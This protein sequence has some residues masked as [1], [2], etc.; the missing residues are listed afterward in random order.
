M[1]K[2]KDSRG[3][4]SVFLIIILVPM[5]LIASIFVDASRFKLAEGVADSAGELVLN[6]AL[7]HYDTDLKDLYGLFATAQDTDE[8]YEKLEDYYR[9]SMISAG[10][11]EKD[12]EAYISQI[13][14]GLGAVSKSGDVADL[15][16]IQ[17]IDFGISKNTNLTLANASVLKK[18]VVDFMKYRAPINTGL[19]FVTSLKSFTTL[20]KQTE[21]VEKRQEYY[22]AEKTVMTAAQKAWDSIN[23]YN[24]TDI[25][26]NTNYLNELKSFLSSNDENSLRNMYES[27]AKKTVKDLYDTQSYAH[28]E[29]YYWRFKEETKKI[30][31]EDKQVWVLKNGTNEKKHY[32]EYTTYSDS[33]K[34]SLND[35][36]TLI[37]NYHNKLKNFKN[38]YSRYINEVKAKMLSTNYGLQTLVQ[39]QRSNKFSI[40]TNYTGTM[41]NSGGLYE[42][43]SKLKHAVSYHEDEPN[44]MLETIS[45]DYGRISGTVGDVYNAIRDEFESTITTQYNT[46]L[47]EVNNFFQPIEDSINNSNQT[48][49]SGVQTKLSDTATK[50]KTYLDT[51][52]TAVDK[53]SVAIINLEAVLKG[54]K[55]GGDLDKKTNS[56]KTVANDSTVKNTSMAVQDRAEIN[57]LNDYLNPEDVQKLITRLTKIK[58]NINNVLSEL[59]KYKYM[60]KSIVSIDGYESLKNLLANKI[61]D[62]QLKSVPL[63]KTSLENKTKEWCEN[64]F[65]TGNINVSWVNDKNQSPILHGPN[66]DTLKFYAYLYTHF[67]KGE[68]STNTEKKI[69][70]KSN[71]TEAESSLKK[72]KSDATKS[73]TKVD[74]KE[75]TTENEISKISIK[76]SKFGGN[77][78]AYASVDYSKGDA[79]T[80]TKTGLSGMLNKICDAI[81]NMGTELRDNL[82]FTDYIMSMFSYDTIE[83]ETAFKNANDV[84][85]NEKVV[86]PETLTKTP[87][88]A[89]NNYAY[90]REIEYVIYGGA[91][92]ENIKNACSSIYG[93]RLAFNMIYAFSASQIR[94]AAF[95]MATPISAASLGVIPVPLIQAAIIVGMACCESALDINDLRTGKPVVLLKSEDT[96]RC[97]IDGLLDEVKSTASTL[98]NSALDKEIDKGVSELNKWLDMTDEQLNEILSQGEEAVNDS[99]STSFD[100]IVTRHADTAIQKLT[101]AI[102]N[103]IEKY[104]MGS[105]QENQIKSSVENELDRWLA[106]GEGVGNALGK[107][108]CSTAVEVIKTYCNNTIDQLIK[109]VIQSQESVTD[110]ISDVSKQMSSKLIDIKQEILTEVTKIS[111]VVK[112]SKE[113]LISSTRDAING[114]ADKLKESLQSNLGNLFGENESNDESGV[115]SIMDFYYSDYLKLFVLIGLYTNEET[116]IL[117]CADAIQSNMN[118][119]N[120]GYDITKASTYVNVTADIQIKPLLLALPLFSDVENN[121]ATNQRCYVFQEK[122]TKGY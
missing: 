113:Q 5:L 25:V 17:L 8:L 120:D 41:T 93:F 38:Y 102:T 42:L 46:T 105:I 109:L 36:K 107:E 76:P 1:K 84:N 73:A 7:T 61:G 31:N 2:N 3:A 108:I 33:K 51:L 91:N 90:R 98:I 72:I 10:L 27:S 23:E 24:K 112:S 71:G 82:Y 58:D 103:S 94:D 55:E 75:V 85:V 28:Y 20:S 12:T 32:G 29:G 9:L 80:K 67:N 66:V 92:K 87:I 11:S 44:V 116:I 110:A 64:K 52:K 30:N 104:K 56:W 21:L 78:D 14:E 37:S 115:S 63:D 111:S 45:I 83:K 50:I 89:E 18:Q 95:A 106:S 6:S 77:P 79:V 117:R 96:W 100:E 65:S 47:N 43:Y 114:G 40:V 119:K 97:S 34:A 35:I 57:S 59:D 49:T 13:M 26:K 39:Y 60:D 15:L 70:N 53:L 62:G 16:D 19:S 118:L 54:V 48:D 74:D 101:T 81:K 4:V 86:K 122:I 99:L 121:P 68:V 22:E 69:E 88:N